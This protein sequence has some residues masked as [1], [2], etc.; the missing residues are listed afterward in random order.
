MRQN[1]YSVP[2]RL[3]GRQVPVLLHASEVVV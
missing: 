2:V 3:T 1:H